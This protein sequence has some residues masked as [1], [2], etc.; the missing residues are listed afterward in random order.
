MPV[1][2]ASTWTPAAVLFVRREETTLMLE[3]EETMLM[4]VA[5]LFTVKFSASTFDDPEIDR[6]VPPPLP[7]NVRLS[8]TVP[9]APLR[10]RAVPGALTIVKAFRISFAP[11]T[12]RADPPMLATSIVMSG[13]PA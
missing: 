3:L 7:D 4:P 13:T 11:L 12:V 8:R 10:A 9:L 2:V 6:P 1:D 5:R